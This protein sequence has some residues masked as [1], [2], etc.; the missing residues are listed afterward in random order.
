MIPVSSAT[1]RSAVWVS[2]SPGSMW[3]FGQAPFDAA[4]AVAAGDDRRAR[5]ALVDVDDDPAR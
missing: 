1:S 4:G 3:P 5:G 2:V